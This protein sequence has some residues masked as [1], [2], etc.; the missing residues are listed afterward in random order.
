LHWLPEVDDEV[1]VAFE[2]G[3]MHRPYV[4][5]G[6]W[7]QP[8]PP[9]ASNQASVDS[10]GAVQLRGLRSREG[11]ILQVN[12]E[13]GSQYIRIAN[14]DDD[15][16]VTI[17]HD[18]KVLEVLSNGDITI[19]GPKG[20]IIVEAGQDVEIKSGANLKIEASANIE[21][22]ASA[23]LTMKGGAQT[24]VEAGTQMSV[25]GAQT[26][27]E[28]SAMAELKGGLVRIN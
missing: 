13:P 27:V 7:S 23:N 24:S 8:D 18:D 21:I 12:D 5:G 11:F 17:A 3:D 25:S 9:P 2:H 19:K 14:P 20:K 1:L 4:L 22:I 16:R 6:L 28:G 26:S 15:S 10:S